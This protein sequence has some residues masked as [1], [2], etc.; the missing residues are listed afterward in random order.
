[1]YVHVRTRACVIRRETEKE[2]G[3]KK[4]DMCISVL[5]IRAEYNKR[6]KIENE[7]REKR[8]KKIRVNEANIARLLLEGGDL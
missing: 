2:R 6:E 4:E 1:M 5:E 3:G 8:S 7:K